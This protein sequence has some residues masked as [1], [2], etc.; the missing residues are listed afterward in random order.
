[1]VDLNIKSSSIQAFFILIYIITSC[2]DT[3]DS[4]LY[5]SLIPIYCRLLVKTKV[6]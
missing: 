5:S 1:M 6:V 4:V 3:L 2:V